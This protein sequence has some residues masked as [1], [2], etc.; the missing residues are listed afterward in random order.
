MV[1]VRSVSAWVERCERR[2]GWSRRE[3]ENRIIAD[4]RRAIKGLDSFRFHCQPVVKQKV[5]REVAFTLPL[6]CWGFK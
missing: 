2:A 5:E 6:E 4:K 1:Y 3:R